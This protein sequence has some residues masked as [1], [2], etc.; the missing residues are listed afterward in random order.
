M[1]Y[2]H[3]S[4]QIPVLQ[5]SMLNKILSELYQ[6]LNLLTVNNTTPLLLSL[7]LSLT[8]HSRHSQPSLT[9]LLLHSF[10][11]PLSHTTHTRL[12]H[13]TFT[14]LVHLSYP[15]FFSHP[16]I[17]PLAL[18]LLYPLTSFSSLSLSPPLFHPFLSLT[19]LS[20]PSLSH[21]SLSH[22]SIS[23]PTVFKIV[24]WYFANQLYMSEMCI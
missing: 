3:E 8:P 4:F 9:P 6:S 24:S 19:P 14:Q 10:L 15:T 1:K 7:S 2:V 23:P 21:P 17:S 18:N 16:T 12:Y 11:N 22:P 5:A 20:H 13:P